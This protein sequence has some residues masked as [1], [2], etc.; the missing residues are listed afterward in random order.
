MNTEEIIAFLH[1]SEKKTPVKVY[2]KEK[3]PIPFKDCM[4]F[5]N[6]DKIIFG[7]WKV[8][9]PI[10]EENKDHILEFV[11][12][13]TCVNSAV[14]LFDSKNLNARIEP[15]AILRDHVEIGNRVI[16]MMGAI[17]NIGVSIQEDTMIDMN[18]VL[19]GRV[20]VGKRCHI[21]AGAVLAGVIEP[22]SATPVIVEDDVM[23]GAN[24]VIL[25]GVHIGK[26]AVVA[27][28]AVVVDDV[29]SYSV[30]AGCP[31]H[32]IK[33]KDNQTNQKTTFI[34]ELRKL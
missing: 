9:Q 24:A 14:P 12:E 7:D 8:I 27:A 19:G 15:G 5:G 21:G 28:G 10:L 30:V 13:H 17:I 16:I 20:Q 4:V 32:I 31:A 2:L 1:Q 25:E 26:H 34:K 33:K 22:A 6:T 23:I 3:K 11:V 18:A 29:P